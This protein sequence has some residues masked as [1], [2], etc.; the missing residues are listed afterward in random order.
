MKKLF[1]T[2]GLLATLVSLTACGS[3]KGD[4]FYSKNVGK[5]NDFLNSESM[6]EAIEPVVSEWHIID[7]NGIPKLFVIFK[8]TNSYDIYIEFDVTYFQNGK[9]IGT[10]QDIGCIC[11]AP[12]EEYFAYDTDNVKKYADNIRVNFLHYG[13]CET[14]KSIKPT[15][16]SIKHVPEDK[17]FD[18][19]INKIDKFEGIYLYILLFNND[20]VTGFT[21]EYLL[22]PTDPFKFSC[23]YINDCNKYVV[24]LIGYDLRK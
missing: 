10:S 22:Q 15:L 13:Y 17:R 7:D 20:I 11:I 18:V 19:E 2:L 4:F 3:A 8:N 6:P 12:N 23:G 24:Y 9:E 14:Y 1:K 16:K 5:S 21:F